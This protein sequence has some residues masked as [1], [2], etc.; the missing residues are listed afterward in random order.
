MPDGCD[1]SVL[2]RVRDEWGS[3][4]VNWR[5]RRKEPERERAII[6]EHGEHATVHVL[7]SK[8]AARA[9]LANVATD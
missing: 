9:F 2:Q 1:D 7:S 3:I 6:G 5:D 8:R 4:G